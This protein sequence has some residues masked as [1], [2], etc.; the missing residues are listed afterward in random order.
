MTSVRVS[1]RTH[2]VTHV[3]T[4]ILWGLRRIV[5]DCGLDQTNMANQWAVL[6]A[7]TSAWLTSG[8]LRRWCLRSMTRGTPP[9]TT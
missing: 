1:T 9:A 5:R 4:N 3:A 8:D 2:S 6:E 7:G